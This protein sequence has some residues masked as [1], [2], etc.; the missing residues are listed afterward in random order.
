M[1]TITVREVRAK[2]DLNQTEMAQ[3]LKMNPDT[4]RK[5]ESGKRKWNLEE[6]WKL[7]QISGLKFEEIHF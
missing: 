3:R 1:K 4:Y 7:S 5:K 6:A 2:L